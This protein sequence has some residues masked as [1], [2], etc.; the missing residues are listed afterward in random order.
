MKRVINSRI[1]ILC[2]GIIVGMFVVGLTKPTYKLV[3]PIYTYVK[4]SDWG[5]ET[6]PRKV[7]YY[8]H[9]ARTQP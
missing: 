7:G 4:T 1:T 3:R 6:N 9:L 5:A 2:I 8:E